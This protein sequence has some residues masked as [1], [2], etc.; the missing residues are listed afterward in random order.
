MP[1]PRALIWF[2]A[3]LA[4]LGLA[5]S[6]L[7]ARYVRKEERYTHPESGATLFTICLFLFA[8]GAVVAGVVAMQVGAS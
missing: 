7:Y 8:A 3:A 1:G 6:I 5:V 4:A 2:L